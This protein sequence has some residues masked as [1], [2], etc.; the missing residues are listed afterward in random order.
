MEQKVAD[1][2]Y[3]AGET[4]QRRANP[5]QCQLGLFGIGDAFQLRLATTA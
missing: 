1:R 5:A 4:H 3:G 2:E